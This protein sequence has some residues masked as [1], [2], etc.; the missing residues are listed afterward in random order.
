[1]SDKTHKQMDKEWSKLTADYKDR[2]LAYARVIMTQDK[3]RADNW[4]RIKEAEKGKRKN[5]ECTCLPEYKNS[6]VVDFLCSYCQAQH[7]EDYYNSPG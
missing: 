4:K 5:Y 6:Y 2:A 7:R 1:M 3:E